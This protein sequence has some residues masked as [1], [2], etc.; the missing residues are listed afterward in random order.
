MDK[1]RL[2]QIINDLVE[3]VGEKG[4]KVS[5]EVILEQA[6]TYERGEI[7]NQNKSNYTSQK[8]ESNTNSAPA[9]FNKPNLSSKQIKILKKQKFTDEQISK[10]SFED[11]SKNI[12]NY[13]DYIKKIKGGL[14]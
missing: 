9:S 3:V 7:A 10:M 8:Q 6:C 13:F 5:N 1:K 4:F 14:K 12:E 2:S 11:V